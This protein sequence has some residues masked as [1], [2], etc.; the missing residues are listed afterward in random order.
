[1]I[2]KSIKKGYSFL[3][4]LTLNIGCM[5]GIGIFFKNEGIF[6]ATEGNPWLV[7]AAWIIGGIAVMALAI[8]FSEVA[9]ST[10]GERGTLAKWAEKFISV[11]VAKLVA[12]FFQFIWYP[13]IILTIALFSTH[14][15]FQIWA[16]DYIGETGQ[17]FATFITY[18]A[19]AAFYM[20]TIMFANAKSNTFGKVAQLVGTIIKFIPLLLVL[21]LGFANPVSTTGGALANGSTEF[22]P[23]LII[24]AL[25]GVLFAL[26]SF[27][28][29]LNLQGEES[30]KGDAI[31]A[32][33][34][35]V[36][37]VGVFYTLI[38]VSVMNGADGDFIITI[39]SNLG[40]QFASILFAF[41]VISALTVLNGLTVSSGR[42]VKQVQ[43]D[44]LFTKIK[45]V[46]KVAPTGEYTGAI[47]FMAILS[48]G[49]FAVLMIA[50]YMNGKDY[51]GFIDAWSNI[52]VLGGFLIYSII[53][54]GALANRVTGKVKVEK[55]KYFVV[56]S[57]IGLVFSVFTTFYVTTGAL[58][59]DG[60][61]KYFVYFGILLTAM[62]YYFQKLTTKEKQ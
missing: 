38:S 25:P 27:L 36:L 14:F 54:L 22:N 48:M 13:T 19:V 5:V 28:N 33:L 55:K 15:T 59:G 20:L 53:I 8:G 49:W 62:L 3:N 52:A 41:I 45:M 11:K 23:I 44:E 18:F 51:I 1:M 21:V 40:S 42:F 61:V 35:S 6:T 34:I 9:T 29:G 24:A 46:D 32:T 26:D 37:A 17:E 10:Q 43:E 4:L 60:I 16:P 58:F 56:S 57:V 7:I 50:G 39:V 47:K 30:R 12:I 2:K 31:K